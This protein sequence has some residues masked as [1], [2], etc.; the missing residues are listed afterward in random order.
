M[1]VIGAGVLIGGLVSLVYMVFK[2]TAS[3]QLPGVDVSSLEKFI[4]CLLALAFCV[5]GYLIFDN[6]KKPKK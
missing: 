4:W 3:G 2:Y 6:R 5:I 1:I